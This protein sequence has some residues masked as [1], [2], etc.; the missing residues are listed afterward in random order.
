MLPDADLAQIPD[1][2]HITPCFGRIVRAES[3]VLSH[4]YVNMLGFPDGINM[5]LKTV[6]DDGAVLKDFL[7]QVVPLGSRYLSGMANLYKK[8]EGTEL[9]A[10]FQSAYW[11][12]LSII[13]DDMKDPKS[14]EVCW[15][16]FIKNARA[17]GLDFVDDMI[18]EL[19][20]AEYGK[21]AVEPPVAEVPIQLPT[22]AVT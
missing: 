21:K 22:P 15:A 16:L 17:K 19:W 2:E 5:F 4:H 11:E 3:R 20:P 12:H 14:E 10:V 8:I 13:R 9:G 1:S 6:N 18:A 7:D